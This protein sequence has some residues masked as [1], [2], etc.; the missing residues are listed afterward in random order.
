M[1]LFALSEGPLRRTILGTSA[2]K[3]EGVLGRQEQVGLKLGVTYDA[4]VGNGLLVLS[5]GGAPSPPVFVLRC[6]KIHE[7]N[8]VY[9][10]WLRFD[11]LRSMGVYWVRV[12]VVFESINVGK[13]LGIEVRIQAPVGC[14]RIHRI[15]N[16]RRRGTWI[17]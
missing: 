5:S 11:I 4:H 13:H 8:R 7:F 9:N 15:T 1:F 10:G 6:G 3:R 14:G 2:L 12:E 17:T 16:Q